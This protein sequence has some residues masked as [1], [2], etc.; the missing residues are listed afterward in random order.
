MTDVA[1]APG[2][3]HAAGVLFV[4]PAGD[5]LMCRRVDAGHFWAFPGG[6]IEE[7]E[8]AEAAARREVKEETGL[9]YTGPLT[10]WTR[11][12]RDGVDF[13]TFLGRTD[14]FEPALNQEHDLYRWSTIEDAKAQ[15]GLHPGTGI[16]LAKFML[17]EL[18]IAKAIRDGELASPQRYANVLLIALRVTGTGASYRKAKQEYVWRD[19]AIYLNDEFLERCQGLPVVLEHPE[20]KDLDSAEFR[21]RTVGMI[22]LPYIQGQEVWGVAKIY[23][24]ACAHML[25]TMPLSTSPGVVFTAD[26]EGTRHVLGNGSHVLI[27][28][29]PSLLDHL[30][31]C[32]LGVWDK[33]GQ[34]AGVLNQITTG[35][36][37]DMADETID[38]DR[39]DAATPENSK[40]GVA[41]D[42]ILAHL[43]S[44]HS[45]LDAIEKKDSDKEKADA[46]EKEK[47]DAEEKERQDA[48]RRDAESPEDKEKRE[49]KDKKDAEDKARTDAE[50]KEKMDKAAHDSLINR[51]SLLEAGANITDAE[52]SQFV[53]VQALA[54]RVAHV[55][56]DSAPRWL[57][58]ETL[59]QYRRRLLQKF[60]THSQ[61]WKGVDLSKIGDDAA[62]G[63]AEKQIYAD[64][65]TAGM[66]PAVDG[67]PRLVPM[68]ERDATGRTIT[69]FRGSPEAFLGQFKYPSRAVVGLKLKHD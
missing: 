22:M 26:G 47:K 64:A 12:I 61:P 19:A 37:T 36:V 16:A 49:A 10:L 60:Q 48:A 39:K 8:T 68:T 27:E 9:D 29:K 58:G 6:G 65:M 23:D 18:G 62:L 46:E 52:R 51:L 2:L 28:G 33:G 1:P 11:R 30:A 34:A 24:D 38:K 44:I 67:E 7:G 55:F 13:T 5:V 69:R 20:R 25:E 45:R 21:E 35:G 15:G 57:N 3:A 4:T 42:K 40:E 53:E 63:I 54:D 17:D 66:S 59:G 56:N 14:R 43:D 32:D 31:I 50:E 41:L